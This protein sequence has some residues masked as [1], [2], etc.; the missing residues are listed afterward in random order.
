VFVL[1]HGGIIIFV[2][3]GSSALLLF[4][5]ASAMLGMVLFFITLQEPTYE[6]T[7]VT[8]PAASTALA[9]QQVNL[10]IP[11]RVLQGEPFDVEMTL[12]PSTD[13][14]QIPANTMLEG[15]ID[16]PEADA[17]PAAV[18]T[19]PQQNGRAVGF[20]WRVLL[21]QDGEVLGRLWLSLVMSGASGAE[22]RQVALARPLELNVTSFAGFAPVVTRGL[23]ICLVGV[24]LIVV[25]F[26]GV[27]R[28][29]QKNKNMKGTLQRRVR[30]G[31]L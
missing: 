4:A 27:Q 18:V 23:G 31:K 22:E 5:T 3:I 13:G 25:I 8:I 17:F 7:S 30:R 11:V 9:G 2:K 1:A 16:L 28:R 26:W 6:I 12:M 21:P 10:R 24:G 15:R 19:A 14:A 20:R 29:R